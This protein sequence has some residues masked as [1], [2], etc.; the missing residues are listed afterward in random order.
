M[1]MEYWKEA[2]GVAD[3]ILENSWMMWAVYI[4]YF[5][6]AL[7]VHKKDNR[8]RRITGNVM[9]GAALPGVFISAHCLGLFAYAMI[10]TYQVASSGEY[11]IIGDSPVV[12]SIENACQSIPVSYLTLSIPL[13]FIV[14]LVSVICG[15]VILAKRAGKAAGIIPLLYGL[16]LAGFGCWFFRAMMMIF[17]S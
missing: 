1:N 9:L 3:I 4:S 15:I 13:F 14:A 16:G 17:S 5:I 10:K 6:L 11:Y 7:A 2:F 12:R 8:T